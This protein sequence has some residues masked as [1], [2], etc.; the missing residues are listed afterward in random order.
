M[1]SNSPN[2]NMNPHP[3]SHTPPQSI[4]V[5][6]NKHGLPLFTCTLP[7]SLLVLVLLQCYQDLQWQMIWPKA[8]LSDNKL[9]LQ[10]R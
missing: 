8:G 6:G 10:S 1:C 2:L 5:P 7:D 4:F 9:S 3:P